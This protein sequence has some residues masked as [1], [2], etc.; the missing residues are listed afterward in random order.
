MELERDRIE[1]RLRDLAVRYA[2][3][4]DDRDPEAFASVFTDDAELI[5]RA[6]P[7]SGRPDRTHTG[8]EAIS[9]I[10]GRMEHYERT[11][12]MLGQSAYTIEGDQASGTVY[13][14]AH[15][16]STSDDGSRDYIMYI[17]YRDRY[18][19]VGDGS[20]QIASRE[21]DVQWVE[22]RKTNDD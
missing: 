20:W 16:L 19:D 11:F 2:V 10:P 5:V 18:K 7:G 6:V 15:H 12:H 8:T 9:R 21:V 22:E 4:V 17:R 3:A 1:P 13:C 14:Q